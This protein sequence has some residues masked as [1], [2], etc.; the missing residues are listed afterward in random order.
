MTSYAE[1]HDLAQET[2]ETVQ[3]VS[4]LA[5]H[6]LENS[7]RNP[8]SAFGQ[9]NTF[10]DTS[11]IRTGSKV[12]GG[13]ADEYRRLVEEPVL[14]RIDVEDEDG[15]HRTFYFARRFSV[16]GI[17]DFTS[18]RA[19]I[20][21]L[22]SQDVGD[23]FTLPNGTEVEV[24]G[25]LLINPTKQSGL[26][27]SIKTR[28]FFEDKD[29]RLIPSLRELIDALE[30]EGSESDPFAE[31]DAQQQFYDP[32]IQRDIIRGISLRDQAILDKIQDGLFRKPLVSRVLLQGPPGT[33]KT[34]T[35]IRRLGQKLHLP[36]E[37][38]EDL[39]SVARARTLNST[40]HPDSWVMFTPTELLELYLREAFGREGIPADR[41][42]VLT[43]EAYSRPFAKDQLRLLRGAS[44]AGFILKHRDEHLTD[45]LHQT[46]IEWFESFARWSDEQFCE[47]LLIS[48]LEAEE[49][50]PED[51]AKHI[52]VIGSNLGDR[53]P[54]GLLSTFIDIKGDASAI[55]N[56]VTEKRREI[57][58]RLDRKF[59]G[60]TNRDRSI[61]I[62]F[63]KFLESLQEEEPE[64]D[65]DDVLEDEQ[66]RLTSSGR[67]VAYRSYRSAMQ[68][69]ARSKFQKRSLPKNSRNAR[70]VDWLGS[71]ILSDE[72]ALEIGTDLHLLTQASFLSDPV[73]RYFGRIVA[74]YR[75]FR[76]EEGK[77]WYDVDKID[78]TSISQLELD[79]LI[80]S[81]LKPAK[82][83]LSSQRV[84]NEL[85]DGYWRHLRPV[86]DEFRTQVVVDEA[87]DFSPIQLAA[88][89]QLSHPDI[90]SFFAC[91]DFNQRL[92]RWG[93][94]T[95][96]Q[97][98]WAIPG[99]ESQS[100]RVGYRQSKSL[101]RF[102]SE[103]LASMT[104][105]TPEL[106]PPS[107]GEHVGVPPCLL[108]G[109]GNIEVTARWVSD[110]IIEIE[111]AI[112][113]LPST[114]VFVAAEADV[115]PVA[116][117]LNETLADHNIT[118]KPCPNGEVMGRDSDV[119]VF[120]IE[121]I[122]GLE[123]EAAFLL[124]LDSLARLEPD[125]FDKFLYV[126]ATRAATYLGLT[127]DDRLPDS[128]A[129]LRTHCTEAWPN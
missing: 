82:E 116:Q 111:R 7:G 5:K 13:L 75:T 59:T 86:A 96:D 55:S 64:E 97:L 79:L 15:R 1:I 60:V 21:T 62:A 23:V 94:S 95:E 34:T 28:A 117:A 92:T 11:A 25:R 100:I 9:L 51:I 120:A 45:R 123:F 31:W 10:T 69:L 88:M 98:L 33:G 44:G 67:Q 85:E 29:T 76:R 124:A 71:N 99:I 105:E 2:V 109:A 73:S 22:A 63:L 56:W 102:S 108:E 26:W 74:R 36:E 89:N 61:A 103:L 113:Y 87:T 4:E 6:E 106:L 110:R 12:A 30:I 122:K 35:L 14:A 58:E 49:A 53:G 47:E 52:K 112:G 118:V 119:R 37:M 57:R 46:S 43:W 125:I 121:H 84:S 16:P 65:T 66:Q 107:F 27:D 91:G 114:A 101:S 3:K 78:P 93:T 32:E 129:H 126:G 24:V 48:S 17:K 115:G 19:P 42:K 18:Y 127:C 20:G 68:A 80:L 40:P 83:L 70:I 128:I 81:Y 104:G 38:T 39:N 50:A 72:E 8:A 77:G 90:K 41:S 54:D